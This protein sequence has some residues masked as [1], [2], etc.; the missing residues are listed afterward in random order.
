MWRTLWENNSWHCHQV[1]L[2][3][4]FFNNVGAWK[5][6]KP[7]S[8]IQS[9]TAYWRGI[10]YEWEI[11]DYTW[12]ERWDRQPRVFRELCSW[13]DL[14]VRPTWV[15][16]CQ[17]WEI[18]SD[19]HVRLDNRQ[20][21]VS[22]ESAIKVRLNVW[23]RL[24]QTWRLVKDSISWGGWMVQRSSPL[25]FILLLALDV[26]L[27]LWVGSTCAIR[28][29]WST[30]VEQILLAGVEE[31]LLH[32]LGDGKLRLHSA[33]L[34]RMGPTFSILQSWSLLLARLRWAWSLCLTACHEH[35]EVLLYEGTRVE[36][37]IDIF[38]WTI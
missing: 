14:C 15:E 38:D 28:W 6:W 23:D 21:R 12:G 2:T 18:W 27:T 33:L 34:P 1:T 25:S 4:F 13:A 22:R 9:S 36:R 3:Q 10:W 20:I 24:W 8:W 26:Q 17:E 32:P 5:C 7:H 31:C 29:F 19:T 16:V 35:W 11:R 37:H 30:R